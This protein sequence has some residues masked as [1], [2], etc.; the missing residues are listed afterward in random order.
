MKP[1]SEEIESEWFHLI[2]DCSHDSDV[3][4][5]MI[6]AVCVACVQALVFWSRLRALFQT[7]PTIG[8]SAAAH[9]KS[10]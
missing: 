10:Y 3:Y 9:G 4:D 2:F 8:P 5:Q 1:E 6:T 7:R